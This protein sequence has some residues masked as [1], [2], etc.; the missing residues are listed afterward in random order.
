MKDLWVDADVLLRL[1]TGDPPAQARK[2]LALAKKAEA[3][4]VRLRVA[5]LV[6][7]EVVWTLTSFYGY[8]RQRVAEVLAPLFEARA[9]RYERPTF[10]TSKKHFASQRASVSRKC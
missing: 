1:L 7:A 2:V 10:L 9:G 3:G 5:P 6:V 8:T 4:E